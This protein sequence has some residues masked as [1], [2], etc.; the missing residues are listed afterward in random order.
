MN[1]G[2]L[3]RAAGIAWVFLRSRLRLAIPSG[4]S[5]SPSFTSILAQRPSLNSM[6]TSTSN[7]SASWQ[8]RSESREAP[9]NTDEHA[10]RSRTQ[11]L[12]QQSERLS[13]GKQ[14]ARIQTQKL[15]EYRGWRRKRRS[16][17]QWRACI[18]LTS[19]TCPQGR[20]APDRS[21]LSPAIRKCPR[22]APPQACRRRLCRVPSR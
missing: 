2:S 5:F 7:P 10:R 11:R 15:R 6:I 13:V 12:E 16:G 14:P 4:T 20:I 21:S 22:F 19:I 17:L 1:D 9:G 18:A 8:R 3:L